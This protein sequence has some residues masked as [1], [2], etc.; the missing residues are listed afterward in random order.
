[1]RLTKKQLEEAMEMQEQGKSVAQIAYKYHVHETT[2]RRYMRNFE[3]YGESL[4]STYPT[5]V[6]EDARP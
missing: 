4:W 5:D 2:I 6:A 1:V 3:R